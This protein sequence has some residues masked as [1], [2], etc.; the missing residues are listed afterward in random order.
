M[1]HQPPSFPFPPPSPQ[2]VPPEYSGVDP[3]YAHA[4]PPNFG[5]AEPGSWGAPSSPEVPAVPPTLERRNSRV[6]SILVLAGAALLVLTLLTPWFA[7]SLTGTDTHNVAV[8]GYENLNT[9]NVCANATGT[10]SQGTTANAGG[11]FFYYQAGGIG[12][13]FVLAAI[14]VLLS[15]VLAVISGV[16]GIRASSA[17]GP[18]V[19]KQVK[20]PYTLAR[21][22]FVLLL[23]A[24]LL[25][26][27]FSIILGGF[28][29]SSICVPGTSASAITGS[30]AYTM[31][32]GSDPISGNMTWGPGTALFASL[33]GLVLMAIGFLRLRAYFKEMSAWDPA[34]QGPTSVPPPAPYPPY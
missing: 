22:A 4:G 13:L 28:I 11:C 33:M 27:L 18:V 7:F 6:P 19:T 16:L 21:N 34:F 30:C 9:F 20:R 8:S 5:G 2:G 10:N 29:V 32:N 25:F 31:P 23:V 12:F 24:T 26:L 14:L 17:Q 15:L 1:A 3:A